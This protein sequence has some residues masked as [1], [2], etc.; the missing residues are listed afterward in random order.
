MNLSGYGYAKQKTSKDGL[1]ELTEVSI[2]ATPG[3]LR[4]IATF[5]EHCAGLIEQHGPKFGHEHLQDQ[6]DLRPWNSSSLDI[7][8]T[9][10]PHP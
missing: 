4:R 8:V 6:Q 5:L 3:E 7:I 10:R 9:S 2:S 1:L